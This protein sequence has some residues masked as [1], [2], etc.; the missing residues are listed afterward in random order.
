[1]GSKLHQ[2]LAVERDLENQKKKIIG[3]TRKVLGEHHLF[4]GMLKTLNMFDEGRKREEDGQSTSTQPTTDV[5]TRINYTIPFITRHLDCVF[6]K[7][8]TN[9]KAVADI[10]IDGDIL[11]KDVPATMLLA[12]EREF[13]GYREI[14]QNIPVMQSGI[15]WAKDDTIAGNFFK[16]STPIKT[17]KV[18]KDI[19]YRVV[20]QPTKEHPAQIKEVPITKQVGEYTEYKWSGCVTLAKKADLLSRLEAFIQAVKKARARANAQEVQKVESTKSIFDW[21]LR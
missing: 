6:Q 4:N 3:E 5:M 12:M 19:E 8:S 16:T 1:M 15:E 2:V 9:T 21:I 18:E 14:F 13:T 10:I 17:Q 11:M 20:V 7:E